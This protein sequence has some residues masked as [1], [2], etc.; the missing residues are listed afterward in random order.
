MFGNSGALRLC[1]LLMTARPRETNLR[2]AAKV[3]KTA[4]TLRLP[5]RQILYQKAKNISAHDFPNLFVSES[6]PYQRVGDL[7]KPACIERLDDGPVKI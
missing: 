3:A 4:K 7:N 6:F 2:Q 1:E 5:S